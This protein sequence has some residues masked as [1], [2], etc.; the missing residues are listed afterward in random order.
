MLA[1]R[2]VILVGLALVLVAC[3]D[4]PQ[5]PAPPRSQAVIAARSGALALVQA[6]VHAEVLV[7]GS[8]TGVTVLN[9]ATGSKRFNGSGT[10]AFADWSKFFT[11]TIT[12]GTTVLKEY[13]TTTGKTLST[14]RLQGELAIRVVS[15]D[16]AKVALMAPL[17]AHASLWT[18]QP[19]GFTDILVPRRS[20]RSVP[21]VFT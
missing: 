17:P 15:D 3:S 12:A 4:A 9:P 6:G 18:P 1:R 20:G 14:V 21:S 16:G 10:P 11:A 13:E 2:L 7:L 8:R 5:P 19:R